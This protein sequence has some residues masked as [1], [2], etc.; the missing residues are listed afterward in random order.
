MTR[1]VIFFDIDGTL[2]STGGAGQQA[3]ERTLI[4]EFKIDFPFEGV[5]TAGRT[6]RGITDEIFARYGFE[7]TQGNRD[8]F[9]DAYLKQL[10]GCLSDSPGQLLPNVREVL[11]ALAQQSHIKL[12]L[13]TGN[14]TDAAWIKLK[15][16]GLDQFFEFGGFGDHNA[17]RNDVARSA[18]NIAAQALN[19]QLHGADTMVIGDTPADIHC[20]RSIGASVVAVA[21]GVYKSHQLASESP[22]HLCEDFQQT[23]AVVDTILSLLS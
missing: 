3:M 19:R 16:F 14:Y 13:L 15:H 1:K 5:L 22:D 11:D 21:T 20:A 4:D 12:S 7:N 2:L 10:P 8:R 6:D 18:L 9:R 23:E 17:N